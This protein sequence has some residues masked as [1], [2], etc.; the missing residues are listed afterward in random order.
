MFSSSYCM[1]GSVMCSCHLWYLIQTSHNLAGDLLNVHEKQGNILWKNKAIDLVI[2][3]TGICIS[4]VLCDFE[5]NVWALSVI[6]KDYSCID[7]LYYHLVLLLYY[8]S[9]FFKFPSEIK[10]GLNN[11]L[12]KCHSKD[13]FLSVFLFSNELTLMVLYKQSHYDK[14]RPHKNFYNR[15]QYLN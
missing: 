4:A 13:L 14:H 2:S 3:R 10:K 11:F 9:R 15:K 12:R 1:T 8:F 7:L 5:V 6:W